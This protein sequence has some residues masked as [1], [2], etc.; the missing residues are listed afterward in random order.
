MAEPEKTPAEVIT[1]LY[2]AFNA[3]DLVRLRALWAEDGVYCT[4]SD[5]FTRRGI[6]AIMDYTENQLI[7][8]FPDAKATIERMVADG[9]QVILDTSVQMTHTAPFSRVTEDGGI[10][11]IPATNR[12]IVTHAIDWFTVRDGKI[13]EDR[14]FFDRMELLEKLGL[15]PQPADA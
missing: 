4:P 5:G 8:P 12:R 15:T 2:D 6:E 3:K 11:E 13:V 10:A 7:R 1:E 9:D 14:L